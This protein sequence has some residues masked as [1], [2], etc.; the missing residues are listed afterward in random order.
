MSLEIDTTTSP[1]G[2]DEDETSAS[3]D[4]IKKLLTRLCYGDFY[5]LGQLWINA[6]KAVLVGAKM[7]LIPSVKAAKPPRPPEKP[8][9]MKYTDLPLYTSPHY[10]YKDY[11]ANKHKCPKVNTKL[12]HEKLVPYVSSLR[13]STQSSYCE[14][15]SDLCEIRNEICTSLKEKKINFKKYMRDSENL[16]LRQA[17][18]VLG[19]VTGFYL[20]S[21][22]GI[23]RRLF[24]TSLGTL[25][26]GALC[27]PKETDE[28]FR[29]FIYHSG[30]LAIA[31]YNSTCGKG[32][33][34]K[35]RLPCRD[36]LPPPPQPRKCNMCPSK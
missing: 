29:N 11:L 22:K 30:K 23:P 15:K 36:E 24:F 14:M 35:E 10:E 32:F 2:E 5:V 6:L 9:P 7:T 17:T 16:K 20:G 4:E 13:S 33:T 3:E 27:F 18:L 25:A 28:G 1:N 31:V 34:L 26:A 19:G 8:P 21:G 12:L